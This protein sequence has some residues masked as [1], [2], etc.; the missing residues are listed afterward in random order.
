MKLVK[1]N[2]QMQGAMRMHKMSN[3]YSLNDCYNNYSYAKENAYNYCKDLQTKY[4][5]YDFKIISYNTNQFSVGFYYK[6]ENDNTTRFVYITKS[7]DRECI[8]E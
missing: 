5:G 6:N 8:I 1:L 4:N 2:K 7:Y 3:T